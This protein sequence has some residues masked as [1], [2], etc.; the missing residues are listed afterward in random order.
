MSE[1]TLLDGLLHAWL[2]AVD[3][4]VVA[5]ASRWRERSVGVCAGGALIAVVGVIAIARSLSA[6]LFPVFRGMGWVLFVHG[7]LD[8]AAAALL[9]RRVSRTDA[10]LL[11]AF[12][13][14]AMVVGLDGYLVE[15]HWLDLERFEVRAPGLDRR[16]RIAVLADLQDRK[17]VV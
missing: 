5:A 14:G 13:L 1:L 4:A 2:I 11:A 9:A 7:P 3:V 10:L 15:P 12:A 6:D 17:S 8:L 16:L